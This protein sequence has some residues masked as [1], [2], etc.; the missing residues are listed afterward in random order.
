MKKGLLLIISI[1]MLET[2]TFAQFVPCDTAFTVPY[3]PL[4]KKINELKNFKGLARLSNVDRILPLSNCTLSP[5]AEEI[6]KIKN[7]IYILLAQTGFIYQMGEPIDSM[8]RFS[9][10]DKTY[11]LNYNIDCYN[12]VYKDNLYNYG[13]YGFWQKTGHL[14]R[15]NQ[16]DKEWDIAPT[17]IEVMSGGYEWYSEKEGKMYVPFQKIEKRFLKDPIYKNGLYNFKSYV[18]DVDKAE[19]QQI[20]KLSKQ[21]ENLALQKN[22]YLCLKVDSGNLFLINDE[23][24]FFDYLNNKVYKSNQ[25][26]LNQF[27]LRNSYN[28]PTF[29]NE[30]VIYIYNKSEQIFKT[31]KF[32]LRDFTELDFTIWTIDYTA[33]YIILGVVVILIITIIFYAIV[34][35]KIKQRLQNAQLKMLK[36]TSIQQAFAGV[37]LTLIELLL[38]ENEKGNRVEIHQ[39]NHVLG[40][41]DKNIGLQKKVRSDVINSINDKYQFITQ[42]DIL[43]ISSIRKID[44]KRFF[45]YFITES[46]I[47]NIKK[48][49]QSK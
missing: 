41:K 11:N 12:F 24:Y 22:N 35:R 27:L 43:L 16:I 45:E 5:N 8:V 37:E 17:N 25:T 36:T 26:D 14:R 3:S 28:N 44:D 13:G 39:M 31:W 20:G 10:I 19:W 21:F 48:I 46:E 7:Q 40:I 6:I 15:Y 30:G 42:S 34:K 29:Y 1:I 4:L 18:L 9:K 23:T 2:S 49:I 33:Y 38:E 32:D 47:Y